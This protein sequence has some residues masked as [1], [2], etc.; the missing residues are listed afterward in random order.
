M[1]DQ[2]GKVAR[3]MALPRPTD[4]ILMATGAFGPAVMDAKGRLVYR[5]QYPPKLKQPEPG[6]AVMMSIPVSPDS[7]PILRADFDARKVDTIGTLKVVAPG[8][9]TITRDGQGNVTMKVSINPMDAADEWA[10]FDDGTIAI[11]RVHDYH[12]DWIDADGTRRTSPKM[13][14]D[15]KR[16]SDEQ[17]QFKVDSMKALVEKQLASRP[18]VTIPTPD[19]PR[20]MKTAIDFMPL[21]TMA[22]YEPPV[23]PGSVKA[24]LKGNLWIVPRTSAGANGGVLYDVVNRDG[25]VKERVQFPRGYALAGFGSGGDIYVLR[26]ENKTGFLEKARVR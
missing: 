12:V 1:L 13:A 23:S 10:M 19:G 24:D 2:T 25:V 20:Q 3:V 4:A 15:W 14:F 16:L 21:S 22:D 17:K 9:M 18:A 6:S 11:V 7:G 5:G 26:V 8:A